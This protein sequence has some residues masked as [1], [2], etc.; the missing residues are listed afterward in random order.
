MP[1]TLKQAAFVDYYLGEARMN[2][3][4]AAKMAGYSERTAYRTGADNLK[5]PQIARVIAAKRTQIAA[6]NDVTVDEIVRNARDVFNRCMQRVRVMVFDHEERRMVQKTDE[7]GQGV[8]SFDAAGAN[9]ANET[10]GRVI[11]AFV[12]KNRVETDQP[13][14]VLICST[15]EALHKAQQQG[16]G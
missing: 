13:I 9:K 4:A 7:N 8:W 14:T 6:R 2:A 12:D 15:P 16:D 10:L 3:T 11:G 5:K 1:I